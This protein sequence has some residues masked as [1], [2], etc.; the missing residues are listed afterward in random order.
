MKTPVYSVGDV[1]RHKVTGEEG[2]IARLVKISD[3]FLTPTHRQENESAYIVFLP[4]TWL[5]P[6]REALWLQSDVFGTVTPT[7]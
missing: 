1:I 2:R 3:I 7:P 5:T 4:G 6:E